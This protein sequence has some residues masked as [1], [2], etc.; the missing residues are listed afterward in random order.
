M[1]NELVPN[2]F[3]SPTIAIAA[4]TQDTTSDSGST[5]MIQIVL[6]VM[7]FTK[8]TAFDESNGKE[9]DRQKKWLIEGGCPLTELDLR[10]EDIRNRISPGSLDVIIT[11]ARFELKSMAAFVCF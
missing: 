11:S 9:E 7:T 4:A 5:M 2:I 6:L 10:M 8:R 3:S 1:N